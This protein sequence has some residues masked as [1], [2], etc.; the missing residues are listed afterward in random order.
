[1][2]FASPDG[3][4]RAGP[5]GTARIDRLPYSR[6]VGR[7]GIQNFC[8]HLLQSDARPRTDIQIL[9]LRVLEQLGIL[10]RKVEGPTESCNA[11][12]WHLA[13]GG[14]RAARAH[15]A[16]KKFEDDLLLGSSRELT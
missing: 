4:L 16:R 12:S 10:H 14:D 11:I 3:Y 15:G 7:R 5:F 8:D 2:P 6:N 13:I 1:M 9:T